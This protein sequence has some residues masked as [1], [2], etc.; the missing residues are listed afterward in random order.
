MCSRTNSYCFQCS[1]LF[2]LFFLSRKYTNAINTMEIDD[3]IVSFLFYFLFFFAPFF[4]IIHS[5]N[6]SIDED[7]SFSFLDQISS[8]TLKSR[9]QSKSTWALRILI[10]WKIS[11]IW[12][13]QNFSFSFIFQYPTSITSTIF[14]VFMYACMFNVSSFVLSISR[15]SHVIDCSN[16]HL[17]AYT[18]E[19]ITLNGPWT[20]MM[21]RKT[22]AEE[23]CVCIS[24]SKRKKL[25][26]IESFEYLSLLEFV[27]KQKN[28]KSTIEK[29]K[30]DVNKK[31]KKNV[32][33]LNYRLRHWSCWYLIENFKWEK[34]FNNRPSTRFSFLLIGCYL[35]F[36]FLIVDIDRK[37]T[38]SSIKSSWLRN[39]W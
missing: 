14:Y 5:I 21:V 24:R 7:F 12:E 13:Q 33:A 18:D 9:C 22:E 31:R 3:A 20:M 2:L 39:D 30:P 16:T 38:R 10:D 1:L 27:Q 26:R 23:E 32:N 8:K 19:E 35:I 15:F 37:E 17:C 36:S 11:S 4:S 34:Q 25:R 29:K 28:G 6:Q